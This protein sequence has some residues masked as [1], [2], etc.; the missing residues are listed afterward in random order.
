[1]KPRTNRTVILA[2]VMFAFAVMF[3][4]PVWAGSP[5]FVGTCTATLNPNNTVTFTG[6]EAG[7]GDED[8]IVSRFNVTAACINPGGKHPQ[9]ENKTA[10]TFTQNTPVQNGK[11]DLSATVGPVVTDPNCSG[12]MTLTITDA[13]IDDLTNGISQQCTVQ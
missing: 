9:A 8:Q 2:A 3:A 4:A 7:L 5:H 1:M 13:S 11:A 6:K 12:P 10:N